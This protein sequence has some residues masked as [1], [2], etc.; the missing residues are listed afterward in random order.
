VSD[1]RG[2]D[3]RWVVPPFVLLEGHQFHKE[4]HIIN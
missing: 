4:S 3:A 2:V 1:V